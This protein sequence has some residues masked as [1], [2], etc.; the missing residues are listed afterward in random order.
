M[1]DAQELTE[2]DLAAIFRRAAELDHARRGGDGATLLD[3][4]ALE[5]VAHEAGLS[6]AA[7]RQALA[8]LRLGTLPVEAGRRWRSR[9]RTKRRG[10]VVI[11]RAVNASREEVDYAI[12][13]LL[14]DE[15]FRVRRRPGD[16]ILWE[17]RERKKRSVL[18]KVQTVSVTEVEE[19]PE[20]CLVRVELAVRVS[21]DDQV[22]G[23]VSG[24]V[25]GGGGAAWF[26]QVIGP[27]SWP[28]PGYRS[29]SSRSGRRGGP[30]GPSTARRRSERGTP[31]N[32][33]STTSTGLTELEATRHRV[34]AWLPR[35]RVASGRL[36]RFVRVAR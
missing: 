9:R 7:V 36:R 5:Q 23:G 13:R 32:S 22:A 4:E 29:P 2:K 33:Y 15:K 18:E 17:R 28:W 30:T 35:V 31:S 27:M 8:E 3:G 24:A 12:G 34:G 10:P 21:A 6:P 25:L 20:R 19:S 1:S 11:E 26:L 16:L 14:T